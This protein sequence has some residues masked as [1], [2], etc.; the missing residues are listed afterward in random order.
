MTKP[1]SPQ[2]FQVSRRRLAMEFPGEVTCSVQ[3]SRTML[4]MADDDPFYS[5]NPK[6]AAAPRR[7][8]WRAAVRVH[9]R[10]RRYADDLRAA[11]NGESYGWEAQLFERGDLFYS[12]GAFVTRVLAVQWA[13][14]ERRAFEKGTAHERRALS[15]LR[16]RRCEGDSDRGRFACPL[17]SL[18]QLQDFAQP[19]LRSRA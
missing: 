14:E 15:R 5:P 7:P 19:S 1:A 13:E 16:Q 6:A 3:P 12:R 8:A 2:G 9:S 18:R 10:I 11:V 17:Q 4:A